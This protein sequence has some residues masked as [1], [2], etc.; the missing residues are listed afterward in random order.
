MNWK[1]IF[2][3][4]FL[5]TFFQPPTIIPIDSLNEFHL[6]RGLCF[7]KPEFERLILHLLSIICRY[8][9]NSKTGGEC[10]NQFV[11]VI[12]YSNELQAMFNITVIVSPEIVALSMGHHEFQYF[13]VGDWL[14]FV[15]FNIIL[16]ILIFNPDHQCIGCIHTC[17]RPFDIH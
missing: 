15:Y 8:R 11:D 13:L 5:V 7:A 1:Q 17:M 12:S 9:T 6:K 16:C 10:W 4:Q 14:Y 3:I 2:S